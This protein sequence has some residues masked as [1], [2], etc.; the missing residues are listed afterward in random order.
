MV[1]CCVLFL[2]FSFVLGSMRLCTF[3]WLKCD[4]SFSTDP[5]N[6]KPKCIAWNDLTAYI[7]YYTFLS[8]EGLIIL[9]G[10]N[11]QSGQGGMVS[12]WVGENWLA[13]GG[14]SLEP[15]F[16]TPPTSLAPVTGP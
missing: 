9:F 7:T 1:S 6:T 16:R 15:L 2:V 10:S 13:R 8:F 5:S 14:G 11:L 12:P 4:F 3:M